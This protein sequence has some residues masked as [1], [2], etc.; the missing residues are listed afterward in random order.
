[1]NFSN[2]TGQ[3]CFFL[4]F[5]PPFSLCVV[6]AQNDLRSR[7]VL[8]RPGCFKSVHGWFRIGPPTGKKCGGR[9]GTFF[10]QS[11]LA[12]F[13]AEQELVWVVRVWSLFAG[14]LCGDEDRQM[15]RSA[16]KGRWPR[17]RGTKRKQARLP[18]YHSPGGCCDPVPALFICTDGCRMRRHISTPTPAIREVGWV[19]P[20]YWSSRR[21]Q[22]WVYPFLMYVWLCA[23]HC[24]SSALCN[25][26]LLRFH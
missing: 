18:R 6:E 9:G 22:Q 1:M 2:K 5:Y 17:W 3:R 12:I 24:Y 13:S 8:L 21:L 23:L 11:T 14:H 20:A 15:W 19:H 7:L 10:Q 16:S 4:T 26:Q 25:Y